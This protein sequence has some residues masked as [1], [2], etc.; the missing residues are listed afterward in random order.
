MM[1]PEGDEVEDDDVKDS[2]VTEDIDI[3]DSRRC[4]GPFP[5]G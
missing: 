4:N 2:P 1:D 3:A 5:D